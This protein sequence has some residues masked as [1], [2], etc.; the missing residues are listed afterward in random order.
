MK[1]DYLLN[2]GQRTANTQP[3]YEKEL[4]NWVQ[5]MARSGG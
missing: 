4:D 5:N 1:G 3:R 2:P